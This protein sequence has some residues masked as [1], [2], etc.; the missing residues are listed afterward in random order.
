[1]LI[2]YTT[3]DGQSLISN[4]GLLDKCHFKKRPT[5]EESSLVDHEIT[6]KPFVDHILRFMIHKSLT[7]L[8]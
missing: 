4:Q 1:M 2:L 5:T 8:P 7:F 3:E 6:T